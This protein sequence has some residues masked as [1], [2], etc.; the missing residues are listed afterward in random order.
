MIDQIFMPN[1][2]LNINEIASASPAR[3]AQHIIALRVHRVP[4][5]APV[6]HPLRSRELEERDKRRTK[7]DRVRGVRASEY[8]A[9]ENDEEFIEASLYDGSISNSVEISSLTTPEVSHDAPAPQHANAV[10]TAAQPES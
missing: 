9:V 1:S 2:K 3:Q 8:F 4:Q 7:L 5:G 6:T 10:K